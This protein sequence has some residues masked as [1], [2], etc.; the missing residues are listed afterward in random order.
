M[1]TL[2]ALPVFPTQRPIK[3]PLPAVMLVFSASVM[4]ETSDDAFWKLSLQSDTQPPCG[5]S[6]LISNNP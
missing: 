4:V 3:I 5:A 2:K 1:P 6:H